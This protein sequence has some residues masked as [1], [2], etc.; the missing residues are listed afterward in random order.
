M[1][2]TQIK[3]HLFSLTNKGIKYDLDRIRQAAAKI[4]NPQ[5]SYKC[6]HVAGTNGKGSTCAYLESMLRESGFKTGLYSSPHLINFEERFQID[7]KIIDELQWY[8]VYKDIKDVGDQFDLSFFEITTLLAFELFKRSGVEWAVF[9]TGLGGRLDATNIVIPEVSV[10]TSIALDHMDLLGNTITSIAKE[11]AGIIKKNVPVVTVANADPEIHRVLKETSESLNAPL[12][13]VNDLSSSFNLTSGIE[14]Q[15]HG[16]MYSLGLRGQ[17]QTIN[18]ILALEAM[19]KAGLF[20]YDKCAKGLRNTFL[21]CRFQEVKYKGRRIL[22]DVGHNPQAAEALVRN[23]QLAYRDH[24]VCF[25]TGIMKDKDYVSIIK[26]YSE[27]ANTV[28]FTKPAIDRASQPEQLLSS[29]PIHL[30]ETVLCKT[31]AD[32]LQ[33]A[34]N[35]THDLICIAGSFYTVGEACCAM[36]INPFS[37]SACF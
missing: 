16:K 20:N 19:E 27:I 21:P 13:E 6:F 5:K 7:G 4:G 1:D 31:V 22:L 28:I 34:M 11:K 15:R 26:K 2:I 14:F 17:F 30:V 25:I 35:M 32:S 37:P 18:A 9:E 10:I 33:T 24:S 29:A 3:K 36:N 23:L 8:D 12:S